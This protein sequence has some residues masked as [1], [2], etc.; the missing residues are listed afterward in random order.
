MSQV[1]RAAGV[2]GCKAGWLCVAREGPGPITSACFASAEDLLRQE[3]RPDVLAIDIPIGLPERGPREC[4]RAA[5]K[6]LGPRRNS[7][8]SAPLR[9]MLGASSWPQACAIRGRLEDRKMSKQA[10]AI[11]PKI[12]QIDAALRRE[13]AR[14]AWVREVHPEVSFW[15]W[16]GAAMSHAKRKRPGHL[17]RLALVSEYF[18]LAAF[19]SARL[20]Y[21]K[22][23]VADDDILD[24][25]AALWTAERILRGEGVRMPPDP[26]RDREGLWM[27]IVC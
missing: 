10:W 24:A 5:R 2:D 16:S 15:A 23:E 18:G 22:R 27:E 26:P 4:D 14:A 13:P 17:E 1:K 21:T 20:R 11:V 6:V 19:S 8:F 9:A 12:R 25:F 3:P 7:V